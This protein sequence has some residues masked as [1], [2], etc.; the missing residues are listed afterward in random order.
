MLHSMG[1]KSLAFGGVDFESC[2]G[3][4]VYIKASELLA[5]C[6]QIDLAATSSTVVEHGNVRN[7]LEMLRIKSGLRTLRLMT[8]GAVELFR[9]LSLPAGKL[10]SSRWTVPAPDFRDEMSSVK[11]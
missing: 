2:T 9:W 4:F 7:T 10:V 3:N 6:L 8:R 5:F 1:C 11:A